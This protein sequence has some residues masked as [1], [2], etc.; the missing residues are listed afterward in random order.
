MLTIAGAFWIGLGIGMF[1][2]RMPWPALALLT[3][4]QVGG[5]AMLI[6]S[7]GRLRRRSGFRRSELRPTGGTL[8]AE[9]RHLIK[10]FFGVVAAQLGL[11]AIAVWVCE[12]ARAE[13]LVWPSIGL[14]VSL[15]FIPLGRILHV[16]TYYL[17]GLAGSLVSLAVFTGGRDPNAVGLLAGGM[18]AVMWGTV[19]HLLTHAD[20]IAD[21]AAREPWAR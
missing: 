11:I 10:A 18:A 12:R 2:P 19:V 1:A 21:R 9:T 13:P 6:A 16:R 3:L 17:T 14:V 4:A 20:A 15:H 5:A 7:A 8:D